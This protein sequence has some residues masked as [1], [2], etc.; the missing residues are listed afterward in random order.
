MTRRRGASR[1]RVESPARGEPVGGRAAPHTPAISHPDTALAP[2]WL[3]SVHPRRGVKGGS[4]TVGLP[5]H[6]STSALVAS[7]K[8]GAVRGA[9]GRREPATPVAS[10]LTRS[11]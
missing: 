10:R 8:R 2:A 7:I 9:A 4:P 11:S 3:A 6:G 5:T 1:D